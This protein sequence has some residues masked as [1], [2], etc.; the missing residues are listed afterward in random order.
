VS[1]LIQVQCLL[2]SDGYVIWLH[3]YVTCGYSFVSIHSIYLTCSEV[4]SG[5]P[6]GSVFGLHLFNFIAVLCNSIKHSQYILFAHTIKFAPSISS[7]THSTLPH[8]DIDSTCVRCA[9]DFILMKLKSEVQFGLLIA[10][11]KQNFGTL[12]YLDLLFLHY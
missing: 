7:A 2:L 12:V 5:F 8:S 6:R 10:L 1:F 9:A 3:C 11:N 4:F